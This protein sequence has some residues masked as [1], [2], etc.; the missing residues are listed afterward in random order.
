MKAS[1]ARWILVVVL[2]VGSLRTANLTLYNYWAAGGPPTPNPEMYETRGNIFAVVTL[3]FFAAA[4]G[5][6]VINWR[7][8]AR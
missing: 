5:L 1:T 4:V 3:F 6:G 2:L 8:R 7:R